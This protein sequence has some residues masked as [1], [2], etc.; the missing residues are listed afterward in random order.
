MKLKWSLNA[1]RMH[2][3]GLLKQKLEQKIQK[4]ETH[5]E[6][7]PADAVHLLV[8]LERHPKKTLFAAAL[9]LHLPSN[10][11]RA[12]KFAADPVPAFDMAIKTLLRELAVLKSALR[13]ESDWNR[14][15]RRA[16]QG[17]AGPSLFAIKPAE[18]SM[19][20]PIRS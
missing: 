15:L 14:S 4:L 5:L 11:L 7:F 13:R 8:T 6:H 9:T 18:A 20:P 10:T 2:P 12:E 3:H 19:A 16:F 17:A 1:K